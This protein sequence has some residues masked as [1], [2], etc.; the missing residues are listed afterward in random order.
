[1]NFTEKG[2]LIEIEND[3]PL[4]PFINCKPFSDYPYQNECLFIGGLI[5]LNIIGLLHIPESIDYSNYIKSIMAFTRC[6][7]GFPLLNKYK[8]NHHY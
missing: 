2:I 7:R 1:M 3:K 5:P 6:I 4:T 8:T